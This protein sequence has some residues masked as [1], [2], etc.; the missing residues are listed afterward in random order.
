MERLTDFMDEMKIRLRNPLFAS[1]VFA[2]LIWNWKVWIGLFWHNDQSLQRACYSDYIGFVKD[3]LDWYKSLIWPSVSSI[4]MVLLLPLFRNLSDMYQAFMMNWGERKVL[5][6]SKSGV[7]SIDKYIAKKQEIIKYVDEIKEAAANEIELIN[8][9]NETKEALGQLKGQNFHNE[10]QLKELRDRL[11]NTRKVNL[12]EGIWAISPGLKGNKSEEYQFMGG[13]V[14]EFF[15][16][17]HRDKFANVLYVL[18]SNNRI[19]LV[20]KTNHNSIEYFEL[21]YSS[22]SYM[23]GT[24]NNTESIVFRRVN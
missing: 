23:Q 20:M 19:N 16:L 18:E 13:E 6:I 22:S 1:F 9:L 2:W 14:H 24:R 12:L 4:V 8:E 21:I 11:I 15:S 7:I 5:E 17:K 10:A 3:Q